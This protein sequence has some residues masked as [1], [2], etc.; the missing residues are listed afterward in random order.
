VKRV[1]LDLRPLQCG[2][3]N[4]G[5]GR[6]TLELTRALLEEERKRFSDGVHCEALVFSGMALPKGLDLPIGIQCPPSARTWVWDQGVLNL[7]LLRGRWA[8]LH[9]FVTLGPLAAVSLPF[10]GAN[11]TIATVH[12]LHLF[13]PDAEPI[14]QSYRATHRIRWQIPALK[15]ARAIVTDSTAVADEL[16]ERFPFLQGG[17]PII[18]VSPGVDHSFR[19]KMASEP[20]D[21]SLQRNNGSY[22]LTV[23]ETAHK[24]LLW[25]AR[26]VQALRRNGHSVRLVMVGDAQSIRGQLL[27]LLD[28]DGIEYLGQV[29]EKTLQALYSG[30]VALLYPSDREGFGFP[31]LEAQLL[32]CPAL[33]FQWDPMQTLVAEP[34]HRLSPDRPEVWEAAMVRLLQD[35]QWKENCRDQAIQF[36]KGFT[37]EKTAKQVWALWQ[38]CWT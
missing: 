35:S 16:K 37:W 6:Y 32:G 23:G 2:Y 38:S 27:S 12:D 1:L 10:W 19:A 29:D 28:H 25:A 15:R 14:L 18:T 3:A 21:T 4:H 31:L 7:H 20:F 34:S 36:A 24:G 8:L 9:N 26:R 17:H 13:R 30:A 33:C 11:R 5:I 22:F